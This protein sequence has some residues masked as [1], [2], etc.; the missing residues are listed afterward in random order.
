[1]STSVLPDE[2]DEMFHQHMDAF[3]GPTLEVMI[4]ELLRVTARL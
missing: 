4:L 2:V 1:M 3:M